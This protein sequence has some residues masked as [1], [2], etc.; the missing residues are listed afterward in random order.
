MQLS[1]IEALFARFAA[2]DLTLLEVQTDG[3]TLRLERNGKPTV[4]SITP[5]VEMTPAVLP[6]SV[7][8]PTAVSTPSAPAGRIV[9]AP[10]VGVFYASASPDAAP[11]VRVG[12]RVQAG[13]TL[14]LLEAM[15][16]MNEIKSPC[17]GKILAVLPENEGLVGFGDPL[18]SIEED[19]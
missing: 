5:V 3:S 11:Y 10:L 17:N 8:Q 19:A 6:L 13:D 4:S 15:K 18:I 7:Q 2:S 12:D 14:C 16:M 9:K 1:E